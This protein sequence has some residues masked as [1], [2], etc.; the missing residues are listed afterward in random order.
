MRQFGAR[1]FEAAPGLITWILL[2]A[3]AWIPILF[4]TPG[5]LLVAS[6]VLV[7]D[8]YWL[9]RAVTVVTGVYSTMWRMRRDMAKDWLALC[10]EDQTQDIPDALQYYH[11]CVIPTYT[12]PYHVLERTVQA[13]V[14]SNYPAELTMVGIITRETDKPGWEN[15][16]RLRE[17][18]G[19][20]LKGFYHIKDPLEPGIVID[21]DSDYRV[22]PQ[23]FAW[24]SWHHARTVL[25]DFVIWQPVPLFHN[26]IWQV[27]MAVRIMSASTSQWQMFLHSR[28]HRLVAF[29]S[30]TCSLQ[31]VHK[32]GYWD[33]D[34]I[35][36]DSRFYWKAFFTFGERFSVKSVY[37]P[38]Y[39]D[40]PN[41]RDYA[42]T[43]MSQYNQIKRWAWG[44][45]DV[46][47]VLARLFKHPEIPLLLRIRR[48]MNLFLNHLNWIFLPLLLMFGASVPI[49]VST[50][51]SLTDLG[52]TLWSYSGILLSTT[53][54]TVVFF[55]YFEIRMLPPKPANWPLWKK[56]AVH[57]QYFAYPVVGLVLSVLPALEAHTRLLLGRYLEYRVTEKV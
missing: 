27:P 35:P 37:L 8:V 13:I 47:Y 24:I 25:R 38:L 36:E 15:V 2:L 12:E 51:F 28:P 17:K 40:S 34:V 53:L 50:D 48:F 18:F 6:V 43:H 16:A 33:K 42:S 5:A 1:L 23:Y 31:F 21:L 14:D 4:H 45:T 39:G 3:P 55:L 19:S 10:R 46:P 9:F 7:F 44:I 20:R 30:Y 26:N 54:S 49:W 32:V 56:G 57:L 11:L 29:S 41:S 22:H 52:Q